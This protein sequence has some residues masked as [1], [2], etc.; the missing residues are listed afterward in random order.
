MVFTAEHR[1]LPYIYIKI[2][3]VLPMPNEKNNNYTLAYYIWY[4]FN[5]VLQVSMYKKHDRIG[6][7]LHHKH[8]RYDVPYPVCGANVPSR[9]TLSPAAILS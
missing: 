2:K 6:R 1:T 7:N 5:F 4:C 3:V 8:K 9:V